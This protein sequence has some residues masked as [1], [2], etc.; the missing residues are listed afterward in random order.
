MNAS[1]TQ[2]KETLNNKIKLLGTNI[3]LF[4]NRQ[5]QINQFTNEY[6]RIQNFIDNQH[7][8]QSGPKHGTTNWLLNK[9][10]QDSADRAN[11]ALIISDT[12]NDLPYPAQQSSQS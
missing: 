3:D 2:T 11:H 7:E 4:Y 6:M 8:K 10:A 1:F 5:D 12:N 9:G